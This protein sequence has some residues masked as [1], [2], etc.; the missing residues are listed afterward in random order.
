[1]T[2]PVSVNRTT[3]GVLFGVTSSVAFGAGGPFAK[4]LIAAGFSPLQAVW[5]RLV[6]T[7]VVLVALC[8]VLRR[9]GQLA[10]MARHK[11]P[12]VTY[13]LVAVAACQALYFVAASRLPVGIAILLEF[14]GPVLV[15]AWEKL[16]RH[17]HVSRESAIGVG[18]AMLGLAVVVQIWSG[19]HLDAIG[20]MAG[21][22]AA[23][24]NAT[25]FLLIDRL[26]GSVDPL[27]LTTGGM[28]VGMVVLVPLAAPW[29][30]PWHI[31]GQSVPMGSHHLPGWTLAA[32][33]VLISTILSYLSGAAAIQRLN[34]PV[35]A[36]LAYVEP[37]SAT[38]VAWAALGERLSL[39]QIAGGVIVLAGAFLAQRGIGHTTGADPD[40]GRSILGTT[41][42]TEALIP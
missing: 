31:L 42:T 33:I 4:A 15:V 16:V 26:A 34:A 5:I 40:S 11:W 21:L 6:G 37:A 12:I 23:A 14:T 29:S 1:M 30:A 20:L 38:I 13:G 2:S 9:P 7:V 28:I 35:A 8:L 18:V 32:F 22:G 41:V 24:G 19:V 10:T 3:A 27:T 25:Y 17:A 39:T 36:G